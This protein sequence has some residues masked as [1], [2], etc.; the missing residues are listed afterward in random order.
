METSV[1]WN[2]C[3]IKID[4]K[5]CWCLLQFKISPHNS[6]FYSHFDNHL[7]SLKMVVECIVCMNG[8]SCPMQLKMHTC[9]ELDPSNHFQCIIITHWQ[10]AK[11][12][13]CLIIS[14]HISTT[15]TCYHVHLTTLTKH[16][17]YILKCIP[18]YQQECPKEFV[19]YTHL[20]MFRTLPYYIH[21]YYI[22]VSYPI[23]C[24][25]FIGSIPYIG[26]FTRC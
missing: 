11:N 20:C 9:H 25:C 18:F 12:P 22:V 8:P 19:Y 14:T 6:R 15:T 26:K 4:V 1:P 21:K 7:L 2:H 16:A 3:L 10:G 24:L 5:F 17:H 13:A 23:L